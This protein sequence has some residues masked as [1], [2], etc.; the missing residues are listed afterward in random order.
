M[1]RDLFASTLHART[2]YPV[3]VRARAQRSGARN[4]NRV[5]ES[6]KEGTQ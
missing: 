1:N 6:G 2:R 5:S 4:R 3:L